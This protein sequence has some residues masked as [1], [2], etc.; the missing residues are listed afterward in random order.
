MASL[1]IEVRRRDDDPRAAEVVATA[2]RLGLA[3]VQGCQIVRVVQFD[4]DPGPALEALCARVLADPV[5]EQAVVVRVGDGVGDA[6]AAVPGVIEVGFLPGVTDTEAREAAAVVRRLGGPA[7]RAA[8]VRRYELGGA[9]GD[10]GVA[11]LRAL[12]LAPLAAAL[13]NPTIERFATG[14]LPPPFGEEPTETDLV[15]TVPVRGADDGALAQLSKERL[16]SLDATELAAVRAFF[17]A[18]GRDPTDAELD[19]LAQTWSEHCNHKT[20]R[21]QVAFRHEAADGT[22]LEERSVDG[23]LSTYLRTPTEQLAKPWVRSAFVDNAGIVAYEDGWDLA[24]KVETHNHP[25]ALE[26]FGGA[27]T[28]VGGVVRDVIGVSARPIA[29]LDV[30]CF[31]PPDTPDDAV[32]PGVLHPARI[33]EGVVAGIG[34]YGNKLGLPTVA[35]AVV[36]HPGY[37]GN[38]LVYCGAVGI[39]PTGSH[40]SAPQVGDV[41]VV[42]GGRTGRDGIHGATF[43]SAEL[44][45]TTV[46]VAGSAVQIG[47]PITEKGVM[48]LIEEARDAG[49]YTAITDCGAGGLSSAV[50]ELASKVG[51]EVDLA[52]VP[53]K[54]AGLR[55]WEVWLSEAQ[56]RMVLSVP[57]ERIGALRAL[58]VRWGVEVSEI[59][60]LTGDHRLRVRHD[61]VTVVDLPMDFLHDGCPRRSMTAVWRPPAE[62]VGPSPVAS[63]PGDL[64]LRIL[65]EPTVASKAAIVHTYD[66]EV[67]GGTLVRPWCGPEGDGPSDGSVFVPLGGWDRGQRAV[68]LGIGINPR[69]GRLDPYAMAL[70]AVDE[71]FRNLVVA[72]ADPNQVSLLD[73]FCWGNPTLPDRLGALVRAVEGCRDAAFAYSA[74]FVSGK[75]SLYN[76]FDGRPIP[77]TLLITALGIVPDRRRVV[78]S[79]LRRDGGAVYLVGATGSHLGGSMAAELL[80]FDGG[81]VAGLPDPEPLVR[82]RAVHAAI[83]AGHVAAAHDLSEGGLAVALAEFALSGRCGLTAAL[84]AAAD[85][86]TATEALF[87]ES[88]GR[89]LLQAVAGGESALE[90]ALAGLPVRRLGTPTP[91]DARLEVDVDGAVVID[92]SIDRLVDAFTTT[93]ATR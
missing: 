1:R 50:G 47:D 71:A 45:H 78:R 73:N 52:L 12:D 46:D 2:Q 29:C 23:L 16:L 76:E 68:A 7:L 54:Y 65:A 90:S 42:L 18:E 70:S 84:P 80:G 38:P 60:H 82:Y 39:L 63:D 69:L 27:N 89:M 64:L 56:E 83:A 74:P 19:T 17:A 55:P 93:G 58:G 41:V 32:P 53:R 31:A 36:Y 14:V 85:G 25:S 13:A 5:V 3:A 79:A 26:P 72:G 30:L 48:E 11:A 86:L 81:V 75:D 57:A 66:H 77:S 91:T 40:P 28:G 67:R 35:G 88:T 22:L 4:E 59:G 6:R 20:F 33:A 10:A 44:D 43:S 37:L 87:S 21:A 62:P 24:I 51:V 49:L 15:E 9:D 92:T 8:T 34:D 61:E